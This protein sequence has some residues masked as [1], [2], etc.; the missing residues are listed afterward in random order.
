MVEVGI[1]SD[2]KYVLQGECFYTP[3]RGWSCQLSDREGV[4]FEEVGDYPTKDE[5]RVATL[6]RVIEIVKRLE[7]K[8]G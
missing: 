6:K 1:R 7:G 3:G 8:D 5:C 2:V 4:V